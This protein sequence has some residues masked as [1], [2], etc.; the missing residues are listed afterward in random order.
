MRSRFERAFESTLWNSR[1]VVVLAVLGSTV[2]ALALFWITSVD[3]F[4]Q[5]RHVVGYGDASLTEEARRGLRDGVV[6]LWLTHASETRG[7]D[8][9]WQGQAGEAESRP[10]PDH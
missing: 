3:I 7:S 6:A 9:A 10:S 4:C 5:L 2:A 8:R 1:F